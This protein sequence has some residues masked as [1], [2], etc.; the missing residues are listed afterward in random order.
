MKLAG[1]IGSILGNNLCDLGEDLDFCG[2]MVN[3]LVK[4]YG[5]VY[6]LF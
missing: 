1:N 5:A 4:V 6:L 3:C 2:D